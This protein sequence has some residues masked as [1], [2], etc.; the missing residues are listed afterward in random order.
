MKVVQAHFL[1]PIQALICLGLTKYVNAQVTAGPY[2]AV[3]YV[4]VP[5]ICVP[6]SNAVYDAAVKRRE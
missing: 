2:P 3:G 6:V 1:G 5:K 4:P